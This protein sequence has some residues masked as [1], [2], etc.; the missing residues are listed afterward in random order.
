[1]T[2]PGSPDASADGAFATHKPCP[3]DRCPGPAQVLV[4][5]PA[6]LPVR[7]HGDPDPATVL[8]ERCG[9]GVPVEV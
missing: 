8:C 4:P 1:M 9:L 6:N 7:D 5:S 3:V 2:G